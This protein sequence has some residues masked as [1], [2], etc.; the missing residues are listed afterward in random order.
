VTFVSP[1]SRSTIRSNSSEAVSRSTRS[2]RAWSIAA[3]LVV[4]PAI[5]LA[6]ANSSVSMLIDVSVMA[7]PRTESG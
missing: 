7:Y 1:I 4:V 2:R 5:F 3:W 6:S